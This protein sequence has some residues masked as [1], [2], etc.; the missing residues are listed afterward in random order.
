MVINHHLMN[1]KIFLNIQTGNSIWP[2]KTRWKSKGSTVRK[3]FRTTDR[4]SNKFLFQGACS[5]KNGSKFFIWLWKKRNIYGR[6]FILTQNQTA[7]L[8]RCWK[9]SRKVT[10]RLSYGWISYQ[11]KVKKS[12]SILNLTPRRVIYISC[13]KLPHLVKT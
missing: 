8:R 7:F 5:T 4:I 12:L 6:P 3:F 11:N 10:F 9:L 13:S 2:F 1:L